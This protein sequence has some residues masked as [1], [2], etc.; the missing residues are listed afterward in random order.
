M[1]EYKV[2]DIINARNKVRNKSYVVI[3]LSVVFQARLEKNYEK[4]DAIRE[5]LN[6]IGIAICD[7]P[8]GTTW[9]PL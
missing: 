5:E 4:A 2:M 3:D 9:R 7:S 1:T 8:K 6:Q